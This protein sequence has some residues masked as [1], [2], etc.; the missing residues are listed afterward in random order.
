MKEGTGAQLRR[1]EVVCE[2][3]VLGA[4]GVASITGS[5]AMCRGITVGNEGNYGG[6]ERLQRQRP[7]RHRAAV[8]SVELCLLSLAICVGR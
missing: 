5:K 8:H 6:R 7:V 2:R 4:W 1:Q 3:A